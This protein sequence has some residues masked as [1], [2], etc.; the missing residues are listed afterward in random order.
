MGWCRN[1]NTE[2]GE[3]EQTSQNLSEGYR[4]HPRG[5][6]QGPLPYVQE[7]G[8][9]W[10]LGILW[11]LPQRM[12]LQDNHCTQGETGTKNTVSE[13]HMCMNRS[14]KIVED[15]KKHTAAYRLRK[16]GGLCYTC[17]QTTS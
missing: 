16:G 5:H 3:E 1:S 10:E 8:Q 17:F 6:T 15:F 7:G 12:T 13:E 11:P 4:A 9:S 2:V 14:R